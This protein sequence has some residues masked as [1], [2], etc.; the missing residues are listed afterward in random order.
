MKLF[1]RNPVIE[2]LRSN[3]SSINKVFIQEGLKD[4][5]FIRSRARKHNIPVYIVPRT[6]MIKFARG[7]NKQ[8]IFV[9]VAEFAYVD[10]DELIA[11]A[12]DK[13]R[14]PVFLD[15]LNDPQNL[16][17][18]I[19][20]LACLGKF[21]IVLPTHDSV[22]VTQ[23]VLRVACGGENYIPVSKVANLN[24]SIRKAKQAG[25]TIAGAVVRD[26]VSLEEADFPFP[27]GLVVGSEQKGIRDVIRKQLD[28]ELTIP[29]ARDTLSFNVAVAT[30]VMCYELAKKKKRGML[31]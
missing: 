27:I 14:T 15:G 2:R 19:R 8:G 13:K 18:I 31:Y 3:P 24:K 21:S 16:G 22:N 23:A 29:M 17:A 7:A 1:G 12:L 6:K 26:G 5:S 11:T 28:L 10:Y 4:T 9:D 30:T 25:F 20:S